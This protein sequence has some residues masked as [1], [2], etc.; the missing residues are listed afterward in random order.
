MHRPPAC[1]ELPLGTY[2]SKGDLT[3]LRSLLETAGLESTHTDSILG[4]AA[5]PSLDAFV[6]TEIH[7]TPLADRIGEPTPLAVAQETR[8]ALHRY[9]Q[10]D[11]TVTLPVRARFIA[12]RKSSPR[13]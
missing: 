5:F 3:E 10:P 11:G 2:W 1:G 13:T 12:G 9:E 7:A 8:S 4:Q 6:H